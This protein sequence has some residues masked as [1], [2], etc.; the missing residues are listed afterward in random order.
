MDIVMMLIGCGWFVSAWAYSKEGNK[1]M[2]GAILIVS[3]MWL[4][5]SILV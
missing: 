2:Y 3:N 1:I 5:G 4:I